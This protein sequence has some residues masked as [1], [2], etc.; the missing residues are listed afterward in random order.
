MPRRAEN[1]PKTIEQIHREAQQEEVKKK[2]MLAQVAQEQRDTGGRGISRTKGMIRGCEF[3][4]MP[5]TIYLL[6]KMLQFLV[7]NV[8]FCLF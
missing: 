4:I 7:E 2:M 6:T 3:L 5:K 1:I 8:G